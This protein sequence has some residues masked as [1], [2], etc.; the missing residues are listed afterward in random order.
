ML[1]RRRRD[2][3]SAPL[4]CDSKDGDAIQ[5]AT[6]R[7]QKQ[8][9]WTDV[10]VP[11][12]RGSRQ[13]PQGVACTL[14]RASAISFSLVPVCCER[15][16]YLKNSFSLVLPP[17]PLAPLLR[18]WLGRK[19]EPERKETTKERKKTR[20]RRPLGVAVRCSNAARAGL[21]EPASPSG[22]DQLD[23]PPA[24]CGCCRLGARS[25]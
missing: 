6:G 15:G 1:P 13:R 5:M 20:A 7:R 16:L 8:C 2:T 25:T 22:D 24:L 11:S 3:R 12:P 9:R 18:A 4:A 17:C 23:C 21:H 14:C 19:K 10:E